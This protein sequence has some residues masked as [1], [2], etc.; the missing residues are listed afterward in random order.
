MPRLKGQIVVWL[1][2]DYNG[3]ENELKA[4]YYQLIQRG[5]DHLD[6]KLFIV[7]YQN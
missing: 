1:N 4:D 3:K 2:I 5:V 7:I 6:G